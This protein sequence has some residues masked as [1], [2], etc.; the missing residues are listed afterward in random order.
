MKRDSLLAFC[1]GIL[2]FGFAMSAH[3][4]ERTVSAMAPWE[5]DGEIFKVEPERLLFVGSFDGVMYVSDGKGSLDAAIM[6]CPA[7]Q[8]F[9]MKDKTT[10]G[11][12]RCI[13]T[14]LEGDKVFAEWSCSGKPGICMGD[15]KLKGGTGRF[16]GITGSGPLHIRTILM[17]IAA[18]MKGGGTVEDAHGLAIWPELK[19]KLPPK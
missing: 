7:T 10:R 4:E 8:E 14:S 15:F 11:Q 13:L 18:N 5:G 2:L 1:I 6:V 3:G 19:F 12:G 17:G 16:K 9:N